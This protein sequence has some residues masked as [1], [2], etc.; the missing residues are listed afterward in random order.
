[1]KLYIFNRN[2]LH[3]GLKTK[4]KRQEKKYNFDYMYLDSVNQF[5]CYYDYNQAILK[6]LRLKHGHQILNKINKNVIG[7]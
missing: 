5:D 6:I 3:Q 7:L 1:M 4:D 2:Q